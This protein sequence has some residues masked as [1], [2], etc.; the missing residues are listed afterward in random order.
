MTPRRSSY[1]AP[2]GAG[3]PP[4]WKIAILTWLALL[5]Q[6]LVLGLIPADWSFPVAVTLTTAPPVAVLIWVVML[7]VT[8]LLS[9][10]LGEPV[11]RTLTMP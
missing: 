8:R 3:T 7:R 4:S 5:P 9:A 2:K 10:W 11:P 1:E 6:V